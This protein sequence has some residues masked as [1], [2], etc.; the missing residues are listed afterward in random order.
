LPR[1]PCSGSASGHFNGVKTQ[2][3]TMCFATDGQIPRREG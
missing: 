1:I 3:N 2:F